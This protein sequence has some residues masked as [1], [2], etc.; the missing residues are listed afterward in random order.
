MGK[1]ITGL[2]IKPTTIGSLPFGNVQAAA[3]L[4]LKYTPEIPSWPQ[5]P[6]RSFKENMYVQFSE[7][8]PGVIIDESQSKIF[9]DTNAAYTGLEKFYEHYLIR[10]IQYFSISREY[11]E[12]IHFFAETSRS[13]NTGNLI[14]VKSQITGPITFGLS[15]KNEAGQSIFYDQQL[16]DTLVKHIIMKSLWQ[17]EVLSSGMIFL[18]EPYM[19]AYGSA[20]TSI[21]R[22]DVTGALQEVIQG[23]KTS[24]SAPLVGIHCCANTDWSLLLDTDIDI[25][26]FDAYEFFDNLVLYIDGLRAFL[27]RGGILA[28]GIVPTSDVLLKK[29]S[30]EKL[31]DKLNNQIKQ[32]ASKGIIEKKLREQILITPACGLGSCSEETAELALELLHDTV[33]QFTN[34]K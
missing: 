6:K 21:S 20:F 24:A 23:I 1:E 3:E 28:W 18:D 32:L 22:E 10:D 30:A 25:L 11:S 2:S 8:F 29:E 16:R 27:G 26:S 17:L 4:L 31:C 15:I 9:V 7:N 12:G 34:Q 14:T 33:Q 5:M 13:A 19:A